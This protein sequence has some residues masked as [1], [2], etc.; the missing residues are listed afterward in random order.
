MYNLPNGCAT[1]ENIFCYPSLYKAPSNPSIDIDI[2]LKSLM[3][4]MKILWKKDIDI[5]DGFTQ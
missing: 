2:F 3:Q 5:I 1:R 4:E